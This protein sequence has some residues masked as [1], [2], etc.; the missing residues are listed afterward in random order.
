MSRQAMKFW[1]RRRARAHAGPPRWGVAIIKIRNLN[2]QGGRKRPP[3]KFSSAP[4]GPPRWGVAIKDAG[5]RC[6]GCIASCVAMLCV[7]DFGCPRNYV[8]AVHAWNAQKKRACKP[9]YRY[10]DTPVHEVI[11][12][13]IPG[14]Q[15]GT[16]ARMHTHSPVTHFPAESAPPV[17]PL[18]AMQP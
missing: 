4:A 13:P 17:T 3:N 9:I 2:A 12:T 7:A 16:H 18:G 14:R 1:V 11:G 15:A 10:T 6:V 8:D 5:W